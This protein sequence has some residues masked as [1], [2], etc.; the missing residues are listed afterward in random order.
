MLGRTARYLSVV[1]IFLTFSVSAL[2]QEQKSKPK[3]EKDTGTTRLRIE[4]TAGEKD[5]PV[6]GASVYVK[7][8]RERLLLKDKT[9]EMN[10]KTNRDGVAKVPSVP[11]GKVLIQ[12]IAQGWRTFGQWY[13]LNAE[14][15]TIKIKLQRPTRWY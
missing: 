7:F 12:V 6:E 3:Q 5:E 2:A 13:D 14:E 9:I 8:V 10:V 1:A 15:Q 4:V 11:Q